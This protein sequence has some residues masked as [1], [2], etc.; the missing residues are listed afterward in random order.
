MPLAILLAAAWLRALAPRFVEGVHYS[1]MFY[2]GRLLSHLSPK[3]PD[4]EGFISLRRLN[5]YSAVVMDSDRDSAEASVNDTKL[6]IQDESEEGPGFAWITHGR[7]IENYVD[8]E[9]LA[10]AVKAVHPDA[11]RL[12]STG[13]YDHCFHYQTEEGDVRTNADKVK[14]AKFGH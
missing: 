1:V 3:D 9:I 14:V 11:V 13:E 10:A 8:A 6:R 5:R 2:G 4:V 7:E 12:A